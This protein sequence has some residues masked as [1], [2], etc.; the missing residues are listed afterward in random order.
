MFINFKKKTLKVNVIVTLAIVMILSISSNIIIDANE[1]SKTTNSNNIVPYNKTWKITLNQE[2]DMSNIEDYIY[3]VDSSGNKLKTTVKDGQRKN[4]LLVQY[5]EGGYEFGQEYILVIK[6]NLKSISGQVLGGR[7]LKKFT[8]ESVPKINNLYVSKD[9]IVDREEFKIIVNTDKSDKVQ[10]YAEVINKSIGLRVPLM[11]SYSKEVYGNEEYLISCKNGLPEGEYILKVYVKRGNTKGVINNDGISYDHTKEILINVNSDKQS[12][13]ANKIRLDGQDVS[14]LNEKYYVNTGSTV[15]INVTDSSVS[16]VY[17]DIIN[18]NNDMNNTR[19]DIV[20]GKATWAAT[21]AGDYR[22]EFTY[23][24]DGKEIQGNVFVMV[25]NIEIRFV[26]YNMTVEEFVS[27]QIKESMPRIYENNSW[28]DA[29]FYD[30]EYYINPKNFIDNNNIYQFLVLNYSEGMTVE[31]A[32]NI[33]VG[34]GILEGQGAAFLEGAEKYNINPA[35]LIA[36][37]LLETG[38]GTSKLATGI[39]VSVV[40]GE[41]VEPKV[42][43]NMYGIQAVDQDP[44]GQGSKYAYK[45]GWFTPESAIIEGAKWIGEGYINSDKYKQNTLYKM[46]WNKDVIWHQYASDIAWASK[47]VDRLKRYTDMSSGLKLIFEIP[48]FK[49]LP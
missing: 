13:I 38:N 41:E 11:K 14:K 29:N 7:I 31:D 18:E 8:I 10:Y 44:N 40:D 35:Y 42:T 24:K 20:N 9:Y 23:S 12:D 47:Q 1:V 6:E 19:I 16:K 30:V 27:R 21:S 45:Q 2:V 5:P 26:D 34:K 4:E 48:V 49:E 28:V 22:L 17:V 3:V 36:H 25:N 39:E 32:N 43:Y 37:A 46:R 15:N 33:L